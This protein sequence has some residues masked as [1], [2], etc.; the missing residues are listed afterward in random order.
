MRWTETTLRRQRPSRRCCSISYTSKL[1]AD[2]QGTLFG[3]NSNGGAIDLVTAVPT[4][5]FESSGS[6]TSGN[7]GLV[8]TEGMVN[9][10][11][12]EDLKMRASFATDNHQSYLEDGHNDERDRAA[13]LRILATPTSA[14]SILGTVDYSAQNSKNNGASP[15]PPGANGPCIGV[16][17]QPFLGNPTITP[18]PDFSDTHNSG[19]YIQATYAFDWANL[20]YIPTYRTVHYDSL[21]TPSYPS[22]G[23]DERDE[24]HTE[25]LRLSS[26]PSSS[27]AWVGGLYL[28]G[29]APERAGAVHFSSGIRHPRRGRSR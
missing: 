3:R 19:A 15:C 21:A 4:D 27:I 23:I 20:T 7:Y 16:S 28:L 24:L 17:W 8:A 5:H 18:T 26:L 25:E 12:N 2:P 22:F 9:V 13:R 1:C 14:L 10:P 6:M 29:R 11:V